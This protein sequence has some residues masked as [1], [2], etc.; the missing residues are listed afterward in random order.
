MDKCVSVLIKEIDIRITAWLYLFQHDASLNSLFD[1]FMFKS[2][3]Q[4][5]IGY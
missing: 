4:S 2:F 1:V 3:N 5:V